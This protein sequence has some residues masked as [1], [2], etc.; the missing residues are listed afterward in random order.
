MP[1]FG[2]T[3]IPAALLMMVLT[4][5]LWA[6]FVAWC[7]LIWRLFTGQSIFPER[8]LVSRDEPRWGAGTVLVIMLA[9]IT[10]SRI[11]FEWLSA[12]CRHAALQAGGLATGES[13]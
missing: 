2:R 12:G 1:P 6:M 10:V 8:P 5:M 11:D 7:W 4:M 13:T 3:E 9:Y